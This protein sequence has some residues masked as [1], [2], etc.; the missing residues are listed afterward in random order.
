MSGNCDQGELRSIERQ[1]KAE[2]HQQILGLH[3]PLT[4][5]PFEE[6]FYG[7]APDTIT[8]SVVAGLIEFEEFIIMTTLLVSLV[9][10]SVMLITGTPTCTGTVVEERYYGLP[11]SGLGVGSCHICS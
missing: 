2:T 6:E 1:L 8:L 11:R 7:T 9:L 4:P 10:F 3:S 5:P